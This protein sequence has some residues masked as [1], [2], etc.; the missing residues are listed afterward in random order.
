MFGIHEKTYKILLKY[1]A[2][3]LAIDEVRIYGSRAMGKEKSGSDID[4]AIFTHEDRDIS[5]RVKTD[6]EELP[7]PYLYDVTDMN[8]LHHEPLKE[9]IERVGKV[10]FRRNKI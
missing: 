1:F 9:H 8:H 7:T 6:L 10:F 2:N 4:F 3:N 5:G